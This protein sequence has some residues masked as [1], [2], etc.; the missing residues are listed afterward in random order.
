MTMEEK[1]TCNFEF[2][3][4]QTRRARVAV[5]REH[6]R[7]IAK[8]KYCGKLEMLVVGERKAKKRIS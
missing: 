7:W 6:S 2:H 4:L 3:L 1:R 8:Q 5:F